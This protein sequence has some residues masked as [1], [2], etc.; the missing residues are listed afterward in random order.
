MYHNSEK[1]FYEKH[2][3]GYKDDFLSK[4]ANI[5]FERKNWTLVAQLY[6]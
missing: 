2:K 3:D 4:Q 5:E 1:R 6:R